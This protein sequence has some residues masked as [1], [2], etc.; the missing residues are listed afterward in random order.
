MCCRRDHRIVSWVLFCLLVFLCGGGC[1]K[2]TLVSTPI[3]PAQ[4][5]DIS[6]PEPTLTAQPPDT[7]FLCIE[8]GMHFVGQSG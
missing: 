5:P 8:A 4:L 6:S 1:M 2:Q 3:L 7:P